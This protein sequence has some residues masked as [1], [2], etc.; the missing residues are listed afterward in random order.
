MESDCLFAP[1]LA[2]SLASFS[3]K[4][5]ATLSLG[6]I[7]IILSV[8]ALLQIKNAFEQLGW[9]K[10]STSEYTIITYRV[11]VQHMHANSIHHREQLPGGVYNYYIQCLC[12]TYACKFYTPSR[13]AAWRSAY[14][15][16]ISRSQIKYA[17]T[18]S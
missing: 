5:K 9:S 3:T 18:S 11:F 6:G 10:R 15:S 16:Y 13:A 4:Y 1:R 12:T 14:S 17:G 8:Y 2:A 7:V